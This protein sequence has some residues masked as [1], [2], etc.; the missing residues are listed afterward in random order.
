MS[1]A[2]KKMTK[3]KQIE[4]LVTDLVHFSDLYLNMEPHMS[5]KL[6]AAGNAQL[7]SQMSKK[8]LEI[9]TKEEKKNAK[10]V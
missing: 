5:I 7:L 6:E 10:E 3:Q 9:Y 1:K 4:K 8:V 2:K